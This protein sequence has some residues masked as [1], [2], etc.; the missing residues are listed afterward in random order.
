MDRAPNNRLSGA[1]WVAGI[2]L[3]IG[4]AWEVVVKLL[5][6]PYFIFPS[7]EEVIEDF[8]SAPRFYFWHASYTVAASLAG[9]FISAVVGLILSFAIVSSHILERIFLTL[10]AIIHSIPKVALAPLFVLWLGTGFIPKV[11]IAAL[12]SILVVVV[13]TVSGMR[14][15][16]PEI[17]NLARVNRAS[18]LTILT[19]IRLPN[20]LPH[21]FAALKVAISLSII[22][23]IVGEYVGGQNGLGYVILIAQGSFNTARAFAAVILLSIIATLLFY[24]VGWAESRIIPWH[25][26]QRSQHRA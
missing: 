24:A 26:T 9:F 6:V 23:A 12:M 4:I 25:V 2:F 22:G 1:A 17:I 5:S 11:V 19:K 14:S 20:A 18:S 15:V 3:T 8:F 13:D 16:D 21:L 7:I 10:L